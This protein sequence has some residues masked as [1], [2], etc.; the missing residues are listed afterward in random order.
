[1]GA[2]ILYFPARSQRS[3]D[4]WSPGSKDNAE[5]KDA[6]AN[7]FDAW[8]AILAGCLHRRILDAL[9]NGDRGEKLEHLG[10]LRELKC[11]G[12]LVEPAFI[13]SDSEAAKLETPAFRDAIAAAVF[14]GI[15]DYARVVRALHPEP[16]KAPEGAPAPRSEPTRPSGP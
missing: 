6:P 2:E 16:A 7:Q 12:V 1:M 9:H 5:N 15:E 10:V 14:A 11:P 13:S 4:S 3:A 8:N